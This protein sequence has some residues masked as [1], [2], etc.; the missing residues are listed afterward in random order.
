MPLRS[1]P[2][3]FV[4]ALLNRKFH[5]LQISNCEE[6]VPITHSARKIG[7]YTSQIPYQYLT[8]SIYLSTSELLKQINELELPQ[9]VKQCNAE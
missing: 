8:L 4:D 5:T 6:L 9:Q 2:S 3:F 7:T 1:A